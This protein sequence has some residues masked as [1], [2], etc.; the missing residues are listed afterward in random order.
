[1]GRE[2]VGEGMEEMEGKRKRGKLWLGCNVCES[3][4]MKNIEQN[5]KEK[6]LSKLMFQKTKQKIICLCFEVQCNKSQQRKTPVV[7]TA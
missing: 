2:E 6:N 7:L 3:K 4:L 1:M 5:E